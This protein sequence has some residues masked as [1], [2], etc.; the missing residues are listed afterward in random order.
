[1]YTTAFGNVILFHQ[2]ETRKTAFLKEIWK[3]KSLNPMQMQSSAFFKSAVK[4]FAADWKTQSFTPKHCLNGGKRLHSI[5][6]VLRRAYRLSGGPVCNCHID[7]IHLISLGSR[8]ST[9]PLNRRVES[10]SYGQ[11]EQSMAESLLFQQTQHSLV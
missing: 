7:H 9:E 4:E 3:F 11:Y 2:N 5:Q 8:N 10:S 6:V 1:M